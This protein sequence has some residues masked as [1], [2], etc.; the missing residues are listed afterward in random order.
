[1]DPALDQLSRDELVSRARALGAR[2]PEVMTR[3]ELRDEIV[4][5]SEPDPVARRR[6]RGWLGVARDLVA[7]V[8]DA[9][10]KMPEAAAAIR[11][12]ARPA[13]ETT[14][15]PPVATLTLA[16]I[17]LAQGHSERALATLEEVLASEP[18]HA[19]AL[20]LRDRIANERVGT[21]GRRRP[22]PS[23]EPGA[24]DE[25]LPAPAPFVASGQPSFVASV[26]SPEATRSP[27][28]AGMPPSVEAAAELSW[29]AETVVAPPPAP[30]GEGSAISETSP[31]SLP[32]P[33]LQAPPA[34]DDAFGA[35]VLGAPA[36][37]RPECAL[38]E[39]GGT[40]EGLY[41]LPPGA[42]GV[43]L[44]VTWFV[45][46]HE[47]PSLGTVDLPLDPVSMRVSLPRVEATAHVRAALGT[48]V[49]GTFR[50]LA[51]ACVYRAQ[52]GALSV[53]FA[54][55]GGESALLRA[56]AQALA[57]G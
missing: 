27:E 47:G 22:A 17:Y 5:L 38:L 3:V 2:R 19:A 33:T 37:A 54:P 6:S 42:N 8:V 53:A 45:P 55:P 51:V 31:D 1:M 28:V 32:I 46:S 35:A 36:P 4:R 10:L 15:P 40:L 21:S 30:P 25:P 18:E 57:R 29:D 14:G 44:R 34:G 50:P 56:E 41:S 9:G 39:R 12:D 11:G 23:S 7:S 48:H 49:A 26:P 16:E 52:A 24:V 13:E 20:A 43:V